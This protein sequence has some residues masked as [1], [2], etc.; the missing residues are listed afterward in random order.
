MITTHEEAGQE[1]I[2][3]ESMLADVPG[4]CKDCGHWIHGHGPRE[5][6]EVAYAVFMSMPKSE[7]LGLLSSILSGGILQP[8]EQ[9]GFSRA[10]RD[11][12][13]GT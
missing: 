10:L 11:R 8:E 9:K 12:K 3:S 4:V 13:T 7:W 1:C 5:D 6:A 2:E